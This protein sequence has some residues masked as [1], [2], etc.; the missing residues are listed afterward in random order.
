[1]TL[2]LKGI[3][4]AMALLLCVIVLCCTGCDVVQS[5]NESQIPNETQTQENITKAVEKIRNS[6]DETYNNGLEKTEMSHKFTGGR[7][8]SSTYRH[9]CYTYGVKTVY[10]GDL[11]TG[12]KIKS[13][14][15]SL[16][17]CVGSFMDD[18]LQEQSISIKESVVAT[19]SVTYM[20]E[21]KDE[22]EVFFSVYY[23]CRNDSGINEK[24]REEQECIKYLRITADITYEDGTKETRMYG[25]DY[26]YDT[27][28]DVSNIL[29]Y[30]LS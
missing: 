18:Y 17:N 21:D 9:D 24:K 7:G 22:E 27:S 4:G 14:E 28:V 3:S 15:Y 23:Y 29:I 1:M 10:V 16:S 25:I 5:L 6:V 13:I 8:S 30:Q 2:R 20:W 26:K 19:N 12:D 11:I